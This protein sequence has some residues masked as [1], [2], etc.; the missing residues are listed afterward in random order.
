MAPSPLQEACACSRAE[1]WRPAEF[2][3]SGSESVLPPAW[4]LALLPALAMAPA[5]VSGWPRVSVSTPV[6][7]LAVELLLVLATALGTALVRVEV[8]GSPR[9]LVSVAALQSMPA[10]MNSLSIRQGKIPAR[11]CSLQFGAKLESA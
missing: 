9:R 2:P 4:G 1:A 7:E 6:R 5:V 10:P 3:A 8:S 11:A